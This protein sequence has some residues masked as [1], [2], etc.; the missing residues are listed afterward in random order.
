MFI[1]YDI[2]ALFVALVYLPRYIFKNKFHS[3]FL[4]RFGFLPKTLLFK[5]RPVWI[6]AVSVGEAM[7]VKNLA[8]A[9]R[10]EFPEVKFVISTVTPTGNT[11]ARN[12]SRDGDKVLYLPLDFSFIVNKVI[13][14]INPRLFIIVETELWPNLISCLYQR[15]IPVIVVNG[16]ISDASYKGYRSIKF[17][18]S[19]F[20]NKVT[21][22][23]VQSLRDAERFADIGVC[24]TR[25]KVAGNMKFDIQEPAVLL[26]KK[27]QDYRLRLGLS[28]QEKFLVAGSTHPGEEEEILQ[29]YTRLMPLFPGLRLLLAPRHPERAGEIEK[30]ISRF[31]L[32]FVRFSRLRDKQPC[33]NAQTVMILDTIGDLVSVYRAA[34]IVFVGGSLIPRGGHNILEPAVLGKA[35]IFGPHMFNFR[36]ITDLFLSNQAAVSV[37]DGQGLQDSITRL[38]NNPDEI[39]QLG[40]RAKKLIVEQRGATEANVKVI[41]EILC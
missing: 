38:L 35:V 31:E 4:A 39:I 11:I 25:I 26:E 18:L 24:N 36:D 8:E 33:F 23:C 7:A 13:T 9:L 37:S 32:S 3:G 20:L 6:H 15:K 34:D 21:L 17:L 2:V 27:G 5:E 12:I 28:S 40:Q 19:S 41:K 14:R 1:V 16:R 30:T 10:R 29:V 22:Y